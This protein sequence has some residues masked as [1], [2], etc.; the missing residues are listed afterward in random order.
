MDMVNMTT[1]GENVCCR[2]I[3]NSIQERQDYRALTV[4]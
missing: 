1:F 2:E 4:R 3:E